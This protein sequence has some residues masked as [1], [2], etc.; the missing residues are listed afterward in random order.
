MN[1]RGRSEM[2]PRRLA[3]AL[4]ARGPELCTWPERE[5]LA[6]LALVRH[7]PAARQL[8][9]EAL[10]D[11]DAPPPDPAAEIRMQCTIRRALAPLSPLLRGIRWS[12]MAACVVAGL[13]VGLGPLAAETTAEAT[14]DFAPSIQ[15]TTSGTVLAAL[16][17]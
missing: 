4:R 16:D 7:D 15:A 14:A 8:L 2:S 6:A 12:L 3:W 13:Y 5:R 11:E 9:A 10:S 17:P 1:V